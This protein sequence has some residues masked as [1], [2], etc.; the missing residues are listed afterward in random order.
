MLYYYKY[1]CMIFECAARFQI[2]DLKPLGSA[3]LVGSQYILKET[4]KYTYRL[5]YLEQYILINL[6]LG[7][8]HT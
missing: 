8:K 5:E 6:V 7:N 3:S 1:G 4:Q 2:S